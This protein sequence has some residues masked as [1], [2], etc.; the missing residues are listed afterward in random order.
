MDAYRIDGN[1]SSMK[2]VANRANVN[3]VENIGNVD[4]RQLENITN[5]VFIIEMEEDL[6][7]D[8]EGIMNEWW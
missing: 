1:K 5:E 2:S 8:F 3:I 6:E 4:L 7:V